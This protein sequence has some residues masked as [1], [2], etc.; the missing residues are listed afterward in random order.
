M[1]LTKTMTIK[2]LL[3]TALFS[4]A[5]FA[6]EL[7]RH[8]QLPLLDC[9]VDSTSTPDPDLPG[10]DGAKYSI[11]I[12]VSTPDSFTAAYAVYIRVKLADGTSQPFR[13]ILD[14]DGVNPSVARFML[15][16]SIPVKIEAFYVV[17][18]HAE[19]TDQIITI[20]H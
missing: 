11:A 14:R 2:L 20:T 12:S 8:I 15:G 5:S 9:Y 7:Y 16:D 13:T 10:F 1:K 6:G 19:P 4:A 18:L 3:L 17:R